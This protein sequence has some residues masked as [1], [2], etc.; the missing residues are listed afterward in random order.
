MG[1]NINRGFYCM[2]GI[3]KLRH[4]HNCHH[5]LPLTYNMLCAN[6]NLEAPGK[7]AGINVL[8]TYHTKLTQR[9]KYTLRSCPVSLLGHV[10]C[11][12]AF[13]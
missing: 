1:G 13:I 10:S 3:D 11:N 6:G 8:Y 5:M 4:L 9:G 7:Q 2:M 12:G